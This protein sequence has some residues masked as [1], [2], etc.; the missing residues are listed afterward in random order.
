MFSPVIP[1]LNDAELEEVLK[2]AA[3]AGVKEAGYV[4][5]CGCRSRSGTCSANG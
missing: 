5:S 4:S 3:Q 1:A 2:A